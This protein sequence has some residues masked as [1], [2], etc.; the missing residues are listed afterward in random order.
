M[1]KSRVAN[2][3]NQIL[4]EQAWVLDIFVVVVVVVL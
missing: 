3:E 1:K 2:V 4:N